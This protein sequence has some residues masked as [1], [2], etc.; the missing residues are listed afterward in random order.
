MP[1]ILLVDDDAH[2]LSSLRRSLRALQRS[3]PEL[4]IE[5]AASPEEAMSKL[6]ERVYCAAIADYRMPIED[7]IS[8]LH[9]MGEAQPGCM[10]ILLTG[11]ADADV[12]ERATAAGVDW[13]FDKPWDDQA[14]R[15]AVTAAVVHG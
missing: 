7:G 1:H 11:M 5:T 14:L 3:I 6:G 12:R 2:V 13:V 9:R 8:L 4:V 10:R 15:E